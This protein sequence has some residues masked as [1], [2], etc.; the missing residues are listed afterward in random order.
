M[1]GNKKCS[2]KELREGMKLQSWHS[3][4]IMFAWEPILSC[5]DW[6]A[7]GVS[8][9][10][11]RLSSRSFCSYWGLV[12]KICDY[13]RKLL[14]F[15]GGLDTLL[16]IARGWLVIATSYAGVIGARVVSPLKSQL[17]WDFTRCHCL[18]NIITLPYGIITIYKVCHNRIS[19]IWLCCLKYFS[20]HLST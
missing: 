19:F 5:T 3:P 9:D 13:L 2:M 15:A 18:D 16:S 8:N 20:N 1:V 11:T 4:N 14:V 17:Y 12:V 7:S 6:D 10:P